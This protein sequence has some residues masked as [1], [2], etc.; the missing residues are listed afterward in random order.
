MTPP[1][2]FA[3]AS[4]A[5]FPARPDAV[6][7]MI[8]P[9]AGS[10]KLE[11]AVV[12][13]MSGAGKSTALHTFEDIGYYC[14]D[15]LPPQ[16]LPKMAEV[17]KDS[18][19]KNKIAVVCDV[20]ASNISDELLTA[21][22]ALA[23][24]EAVRPILVFLD[25]EVA[26][27]L[28]RFS[29]T[30]RKHPLGA[31]EGLEQSILRERE[32]LNP[33]RERADVL[34]DTTSLSI[35]EFQ[36]KLIGFFSVEGRPRLQVVVTSFGYKFGMP[37]SSDIVFPVTFLP[38]PYYEPALSHKTGLDPEVREY[39]ENR[40][41]TREFL[42]NTERMLQF[43]IPQFISEGKSH[44]GI[45][46]GCTGGRHRSVA[47]AER[48]KAFLTEHFASKGSIEVSVLHRDIGK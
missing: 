21:F 14:M 31:V 47:V 4:T 5:A 30:R 37:M 44:L 43:L 15:N 28:R 17:L 27:L 26:V 13:G 39:V 35:R 33:L 10:S 6:S 46:V 23:A 25:A 29:L 40:E 36:E 12:T 16:L 45:S 34:I 42:S 18:K 7:P 20:R 24:M 48:V 8:D 9:A 22:E 41:I 19:D 32:L 3:A 11:F 38:N 1:A 2:R